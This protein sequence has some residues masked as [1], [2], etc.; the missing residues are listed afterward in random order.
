MLVQPRQLRHLP[1]SLLHIGCQLSQ[2]PAAGVALLPQ[3]RAKYE[4]TLLI[5]KTH[6]GMHTLLR[7]CPTWADPAWPF[8]ASRERCES[9]PDGL[10]HSWSAWPGEASCSAPSLLPGIAFGAATVFMAL[11]KPA[12]FIT[13]TAS[14]RTSCTGALKTYNGRVCKAVDP[15]QRRLRSRYG[16]A[17]G[18]LWLATSRARR[19]WGRHARGHARPG[20]AV[21][22]SLLLKLAIARQCS[23]MRGSLLVAPP[24]WRLL[25]QFGSRLA[26]FSGSSAYD[27]RTLSG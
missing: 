15:H 8:S 18:G 5:L 25:L 16:R 23:G 3:Q 7:L 17:W 12:A 21:L 22:Q 20:H 1:G 2:G 19:Q 6:E 24:G 27:K 10:V 4:D 14:V 11:S 9:D 13:C 26:R